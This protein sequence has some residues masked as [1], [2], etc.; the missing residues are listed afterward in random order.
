MSGGSER[1]AEAEELGAEGEEQPLFL[2]T[3]S[4]M[5]SA[6]GPGG[7]SRFPL[8]FLFSRSCVISLVHLIFL[9]QAWAEGKGELATCRHRVDCGRETDLYIRTSP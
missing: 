8:F 2:Y 5:A 1:G 6:E 9:G 4:F 3:P 7:G